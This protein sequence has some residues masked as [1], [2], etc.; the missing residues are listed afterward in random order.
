M[1]EVFTDK[2]A[3]Y[4]MEGSADAML[5]YAE[6]L[7][8]INKVMNLTRITEPEEVAVKH[9]IDSAHP[10]ICRLIPEGAKI[11]DIGT[12]GGFPGVP[13]KLMRGDVEVT[14]LESAAKKLNFVKST[15]DEMGVSAQYLNKRAEE[16]PE[17]R[18]TFDIAVSRAV[19]ALPMLLELTSPFVKVG[20][21][22]LAY[23]G[24]IADEELALAGGAVKKLNLALK[25]RVDIDIEGNSHCILVFE[26]KG[27]TPKQYPRRFAQIKKGPL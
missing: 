12:G 9:F 17:L 22:I 10:D 4:G 3:Q 13:L 24:M 7:L 23:K 16:C 20:G 6:K 1:R 8:E 26:K 25:E 11:I 2:L 19:A 15:L 18:E 14:F 5:A 21:C 27:K